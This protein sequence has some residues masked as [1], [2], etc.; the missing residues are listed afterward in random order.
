MRGAENDA[1]EL[2]EKAKWYVQEIVQARVRMEW[3]LALGEDADHQ[4]ILSLENRER[5][6]RELKRDI[7]NYKLN[8]HPDP[9]KSEVAKQVVP[10]LEHLLEA[11]ENAPEKLDF[12]PEEPIQPRQKPLSAEDA[13]KQGQFAQYVENAFQRRR[14]VWAAISKKYKSGRHFSKKEIKHDLLLLLGDGKQLE[15]LGHDDSEA[16]K[17]HRRDRGR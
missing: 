2:G 12:D 6:I 7:L 16:Q 3:A 10:L 14:P 11:L 4:P 1:S 17:S 5:M 13:I 15:L 9:L 8:H